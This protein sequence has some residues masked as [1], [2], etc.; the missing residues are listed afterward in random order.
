MPPRPPRD[1]Q[2]YAGQAVTVQPPVS[3]PECSPWAYR[4]EGFLSG[5]AIGLIVMNMLV[6]DHFKATVMFTCGIV[7]AYCL[8]L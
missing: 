2:A 3:V 5:L 4:G 6:K 1:N 8:N 7:V